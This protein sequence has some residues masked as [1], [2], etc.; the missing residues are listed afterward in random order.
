M[1]YTTNFNVYLVCY[2]LAFGFVGGVAYMVPVHH[3][4]GWFPGRPGLTSGFIIGAVGL[5]PIVFDQIAISLCNPTNIQPVNGVFPPEVTRNV[6]YF[7]K[8][9]SWICVTML[10]LVVL[11]VFPAP[12][13]EHQK[14]EEK[15]EVVPELVSEV[16]SQ[17]I[18]DL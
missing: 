12:E 18:D 14:K 9:M 3:T 16:E 13:P 8:V 10:T 4:W 15:G 11:C 2:C 6:P 17:L 1:A 7:N 5:G